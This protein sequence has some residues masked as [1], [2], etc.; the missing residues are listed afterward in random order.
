[1][2]RPHIV[3]IGAGFG[4]VYVARAL[5]PYVKSGM[6]DVTIINRTNHFLFT[7]LLHE[8]AT[9]GLSPTSVTEPLREIFAGT[10]I[11]VAQGE[12]KFIDTS[13]K[14]IGLGVCEIQYDYVVMATGAGSNFYGITG[15][16]EH[17]LP[18]KNLSDAVRIRSA[19]IDTFERACLLKDPVQR[20]KML[21]FVVVGG[22]ATGV[23][24]A[25]ELVEFVFST[26]RRYY[27]GKNDCTAKDISVTL[28]N[29]EKDILNLFHPNLRE[30]ARKVLSK[31]G[32]QFRLGV[33]V[34]AVYGD[35]VELGGGELVDAGVV[36]WTAGVKSSLPEF[37]DEKPLL[38]SGRILV[39]SK[40]RVSGL[41]DSFVLGDSSAFVD[42][43][44]GEPIPMF[45]QVT[46]AQAKVVAKN[47][48]ALIRGEEL[49][50]FKFRRK[51]DLISVGQWFALGDIFGIRMSGRFTWWL[52]RTVYLFKFISWRKRFKIA[53][54]W[55]INLFYPRDITKLN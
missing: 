47:L 36:I 49:I 35:R 16:E 38:V 14:K 21:S 29:S 24:V 8:V 2:N 20:A 15:A 32:V 10:Y 19:I 33:R 9:G 26:A 4:G 43:A 39:D 23:E 53:F 37:K 28:I 17:T 45:A 18:L 3:I 27:Q 6:I 34:K 13:K 44:L 41:E 30:K 12:V 11:Q 55:T 25:G 5:A 22:G 31:K 48:M 1:M 51:G 50:D 42:N 54:E 7:P 40:L 52:W 46:V